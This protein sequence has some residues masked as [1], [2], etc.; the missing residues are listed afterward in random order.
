M[1]KGMGMLKDPALEK[2]QG[3]GPLKFQA[4]NW[5]IR[6]I[7]RLAIYSRVWLCGLRQDS[8]QEDY[9]DLGNIVPRARDTNNRVAHSRR[10]GKE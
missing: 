5:A 9:G 8:S 2:R 1:V 6:A 4:K 10:T 3:R 7:Y